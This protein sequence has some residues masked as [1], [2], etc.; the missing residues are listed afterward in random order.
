MTNENLNK[1]KCIKND[2]FLEWAEFSGNK[3]GTKK[4]YVKKCLAN[5]EKLILEIDT[6]GALNV[7]KIHDPSFNKYRFLYA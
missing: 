3:Y 5:S 4:D 7:K 6:K 1:A 2:E